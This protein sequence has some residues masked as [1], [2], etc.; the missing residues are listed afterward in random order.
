VFNSGFR[1]ASYADSL[2]EAFRLTK[3][4]CGLPGNREIP[5]QYFCRA[6]EFALRHYGT[7]E[8]VTGEISIKMWKE[9]IRA[10]GYID[11]DR[12]SNY[13]DAEQYR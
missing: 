12:A 9:A 2:W 6:V 7:H 10:S 5:M 8:E 13:Q 11:A 3:D 1:L 4:E